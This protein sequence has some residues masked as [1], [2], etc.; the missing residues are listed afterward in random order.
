MWRAVEDRRAHPRNDLLGQLIAGKIE[1][2]PINDEELRG[3]CTLLLGG[4]L[5]TVASML[6]FIARFLATHPEH[7][8][9]LVEQPKLVPRAVD[10]LIRR[11]GV[12]NTARLV[13]RDFEFQ[14][15]PLREGDMIQIPNCL[16]GLDEARVDDPLR[17]DFNRPTPIPSAAF[18]NGPHR[19]PGMALARLEIRLF[20]EEW[21]PRIPDFHIK[22]GTIPVAAVATTNS[23][24]E[25]WLSWIPRGTNRS[26]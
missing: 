7:R 14:G 8:R 21:L 6:G 26:A 12:A 15:V 11:H 4:G 10:E 25:L 13:T 2:R 20:L 16:Y 22:A 17:V 18:G 19:C 3:T 1:G 5:D 9:Q 24:R 23:M